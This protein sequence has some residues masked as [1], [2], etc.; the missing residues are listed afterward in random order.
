VEE[1]SCWN[2]KGYVYVCASSMLTMLLMLL[3]LSQ[4]QRKSEKAALESV[5]RGDHRVMSIIV[6]GMDQN[7]CKVPYDGSQCAF[8]H[9]LKQVIP[10]VF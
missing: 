1:C 9:A 7:H 4:E 10:Y 5:R 3:R 2:E 6:D 8:N